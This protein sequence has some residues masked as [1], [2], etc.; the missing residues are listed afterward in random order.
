MKKLVAALF[1]IVFAFSLTPLSVLADDPSRDTECVG[2]NKVAE[3]TIASGVTTKTGYYACCQQGK[4]Y[5]PVKFGYNAGSIAGYKYTSTCDQSAVSLTNSLELD[6]ATFVS[7]VN[8]GKMTRPTCSGN[9]TFVNDPSLGKNQCVSNTVKM[10][11]ACSDF[12]GTTAPLADTTVGSPNSGKT[13]CVYTGGVCA[14]P[15]ATCADAEAKLRNAAGN[16]CVAG[17]IYQCPNPQYYSPQYDPLI[18]GMVCAVDK[19]KLPAGS[20]SYFSGTD[21]QGTCGGGFV[22][23][24]I[25]CIPTGNFTETMAFVLQWLFLAAGGIIIALVI[26]NGF[27]LLT[28]AGNPEKL[29]EVRESVT[30]IVTGVLLIIFSLTI[31][32]IVGADILG[33]PGF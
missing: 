22:D 3:V 29:K 27:T 28:S 6:P 8:S 14:G 2:G 25:G 13:C 15:F 20:E 19:T 4:D 21:F 31:L 11:T 16:S 9:Y 1:T 10:P 7:L 17:Y 24:A 33:L 32:K 30:A 26:K 12:L 23:T 5:A 18:G